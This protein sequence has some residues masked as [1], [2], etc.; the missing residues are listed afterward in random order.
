MVPAE[1]VEKTTQGDKPCDDWYRYLWH[2][3]PPARL[4]T[5]DPACDALF[6]APTAYADLPPDTFFAEG[7]NG[8]F[9]FIIPS[10]DMVVVRLANDGPGSENWDDYAVEFLRLMIEAVM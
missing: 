6:C 9:I 10:T 4:G 3:N 8:Q 5:Q 2:Q 1:W 7:I